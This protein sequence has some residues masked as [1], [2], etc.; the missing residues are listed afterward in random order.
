MYLWHN[1]ALSPKATLLS[2]GY[3]LTRLLQGNVA[4]RH[5]GELEGE[6]GAQGVQLQHHDHA[7]Q[8]PLHRGHWA[9]LS[10]GKGRTDVDLIIQELL[11]KNAEAVFKAADYYEVQGAP[12]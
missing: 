11:D 2:G 7:P 5:G 10:I 8:V 3:F 1:N 6:G 9:G 4:E 12:D